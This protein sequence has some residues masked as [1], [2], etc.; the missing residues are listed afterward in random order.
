MNDLFGQEVI[1]TIGM[2]Q[3]F[4]SMMLTPYNKLETRW[5]LEGRRPSYPLGKYI[6]YSTLKP[7][8][9]EQFIEWTGGTK[10]PEYLKQEPLN[11]YAIWLGEVTGMRLME[12]KDETTTYIKY[13][14]R[15][16]FPKV[17]EQINV[18]K[19][20]WVLFFENVKQIQTFKFEDENGKSIGKQGVGKL[21]FKYHHKIKII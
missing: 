18:T 13:I 5:A 7:C 16:L 11:G 15:K 1:R 6:G 8:T 12:K 19:I 10:R 17:I 21:E 14:G 4:C 2:Y 20:Q 3:P 9:D